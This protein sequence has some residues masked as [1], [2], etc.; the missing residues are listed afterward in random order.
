[1]KLAK[2]PRPWTIWAFAG[3]AIT[4]ASW[5]LLNSLLDLAGAQSLLNELPLGVEWTRDLTIIAASAVF[6]IKLIPSA[7][8]WFYRN[9]VARWFVAIWGSI[10][11]VMLVNFTMDLWSSTST[12]VSLV[13]WLSILRGTTPSIF[14]AVLVFTP[15]ANRW[16]RQ[17][18]AVDASTFE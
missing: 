18:E 11:F 16:F 9:K 2:G 1:M 17:E 13:L 3:I 7:L 10:A 14:Q 15:S 8:I 5:S 12:K 6:T 4:S